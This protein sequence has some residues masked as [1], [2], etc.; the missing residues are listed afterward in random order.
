MALRYLYIFIAVCEENNM[1]H[2]AKRMHM[3]QPSV[4]QA[5]REM[6]TYYGVLLFER[7]GHR[8][9][10]TPAGTRLLQYAYQIVSLS[11]KAK[12]AMAHY[13]H[14][15]PIRIGASLTIGEVF[16]IELL[17]YLHQQSPQQQYLSDI[18]NTAE[19]EQLLLRDNIDIALVEGQIQS[20][21]LL[22]Q[23]FMR[24][25]L[26]LVVAPDHPLA[27]K[28]ALS[29]DD[30]QGQ[31]LYVREKGS[32]TRNLFISTMEEHHVQFHILGSYNNTEALKKAAQAG[33][34]AAILS[35]RL[36][37]KEISAGSLTAHTIQGISLARIFK[38]VY[39]KDKFISPSL[40]QVIDACQACDTWL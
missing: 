31:S 14:A 15:T 17:C 23:P 40:Q 24:D 6:E 21:Y 34:G 30:L 10:I 35:R 20:E 25:E 37:A 38:I 39:H 7:L 22:S 18:H 2:A 27:A 26:V 5:I 33:L 3:T 13:T 11:K 16:L 8:L 32:G 9:F 28:P 1:T 29:P 12:T 19:M 36:V 4:S